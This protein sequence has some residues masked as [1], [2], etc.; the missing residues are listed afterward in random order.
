MDSRDW[1][2]YLRIVAHTEIRLVFCVWLYL[3]DIFNFQDSS[4]SILNS[5]NTEAVKLTSTGVT[6]M[7]S[8]GD[9]GVAGTASNCNVNSGSSQSSW[10]VSFLL[11]SLFVRY[12]FSCFFFV[13]LQDQKY[14]FIA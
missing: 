11:F 1:F 2:W 5:F 3:P 13:L 10:T 6:I 7:V 9:N 8:S 14:I 4:S 12:F